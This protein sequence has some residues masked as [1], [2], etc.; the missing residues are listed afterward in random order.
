MNDII[1]TALAKAYTPVNPLSPGKYQVKERITLEIEGTITK[2][3]D[4][5]RT[6]TVDIPWKKV[7]AHLA[8]K[9]GCVGDAAINQ[10]TDAIRDAMNNN[11]DKDA[12]IES[13][14]KDIEAATKKVESFL[15][16]LPPKTISG[17]TT[18]DVTVTE[19]SV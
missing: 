19:I 14:I 1:K 18:V 8:E 17:R 10:L 13:R 3:A 11:K 6:P 5:T 12:A 16:Q 7:V 15:G 9:L 2:G 4:Q